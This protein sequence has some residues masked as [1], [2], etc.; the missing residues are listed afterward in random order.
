MDNSVD[1][2]SPGQARPP[3]PGRGGGW[4]WTARS[5]A[6]A[7][8]LAAALAAVARPPHSPSVLLLVADTLRADRLGSYG[9]P[10][11]TSPRL[12]ALAAESVLYEAALTPAPFT[13][14]AV[15]GLMTGRY[16]E[17]VGVANH[18][19][20][21]ALAGEAHTL[22][23]AA[24]GAGYRRAAV[25]SNPWLA[26]PAMGFSQGFD[27]FVTAKRLGVPP[28][29]RLD[30]TAV[31]D[32]A[33]DLLADISTSDQPFLL[34]VHY[35]DTH[36]PYNAP[37]ELAAQF[38]NPSA[39]SRVL[40]DF[41]DP[42][43][44]RQRIYFEP[45][46]TAGE[47][48]DTRRVYDAAVHYVDREIGRLLDRVKELGIYD[49]AIII[50][51][52]DHGESLG[53]HGLFFAHDFTLY[54][55]LVHVPM[56]IRAPGTQPGR[57]SSVVSLLD[58]LPTLCARTALACPKATDGANL[59]A[60]PPRLSRFAASAPLRKRYRLNPWAE[61]PGLAGRT[62]LLRS[63]NIKLLRF[64]LTEGLR[65]EAYNLAE[66]PGERR[67]IYDPGHFLSE[68]VELDAWLED[69]RQRRAPRTRNPGALDRETVGRLRSLGYL[70]GPSNG[71]RAGGR[72]AP[73]K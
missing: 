71:E 12:D 51:V 57:V 23:E 58:V 7:L 2:K 67:N 50:F 16:P 52:S 4:A 17:T 30:A 14:P 10:L 26:R 35:M 41:V 62:S 45:N 19:R 36:M 32:I 27:V 3:S 48:E 37:A 33:L 21:D 11:P 8:A 18:S 38:G 1:S 68:R 5:A 13:M 29:A 46:Y 39:T 53:E 49:E 63:G 73:A 15:A 55:E 43:D 25:V 31:T 56:M 42:D 72:S 54:Q 47:L 60:T 65:Y 28:P 40:A 22:A 61:R 69:M 59:L 6:L 9:Y 66:D 44:D 20:A 64:P 24:A 34:W 70:D